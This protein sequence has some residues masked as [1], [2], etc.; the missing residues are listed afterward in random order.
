M[1]GLTDAFGLAAGMTFAVFFAIGAAKSLW[2]EAAWWRSGLET[3]AIGGVAAG[4]GLLALDRSL[5]IDLYALAG[6]AYTDAH[7]ADTR[8]RHSN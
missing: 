6:A 7:D 3:L 1:L 8:H 5:R 2:S 4:R